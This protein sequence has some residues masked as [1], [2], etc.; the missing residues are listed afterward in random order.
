[1][2]FSEKPLHAADREDKN[3]FKVKVQGQALRTTGPNFQT[4]CFSY[5]VLSEDSCPC[6]EQGGFKYLTRTSGKVSECSKYTCG[7]K[8]TT[9]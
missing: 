2:D 3:A 1:M 9:L 7:I 5:G 6:T 4:T 8:T